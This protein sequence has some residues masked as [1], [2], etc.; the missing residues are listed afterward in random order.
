MLGRRG[1]TISR[2]NYISMSNS[3]HAHSSPQK[4]VAN[5]AQTYVLPVDLEILGHCKRSYL[6]I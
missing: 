3:L 1:L 6:N 2:E 4:H 5:F